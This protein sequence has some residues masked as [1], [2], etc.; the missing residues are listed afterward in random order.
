M[1]VSDIEYKALPRYPAIQ[2]D[3][4]VV[5][6]QEVAAAKLTGTAWS[7][8]GE[9]LESVHV[10]DVYTGEKLGAGKKS[11]AISLVYRHADRTL[12]DEEVD[13]RHKAVVDAATKKF[14]ATLRA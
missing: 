8:A 7:I 12:T 5:V 3:I 2:R 4:A 13:A 11:V 14:G 10:F 1:V 6:A 9:L